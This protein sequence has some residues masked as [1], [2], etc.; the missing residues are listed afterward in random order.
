MENKNQMDFQFIIASHKDFVN[1][2]GDFQPSEKQTITTFVGYTDSYDERLGELTIAQWD[3]KDYSG[4]IEYIKR[5]AHS[6]V[7]TFRAG[8]AHTY[9]FSKA[10][11][12]T[13]SI[14]GMGF[15]SDV[16]SAGGWTD[17]TSVNYGFRSSFATK[18]SLGSGAALSGITGIEVQRQDAQ[19]TG[20][21]MKADPPIQTPV[22]RGYMAR[23][24]IGS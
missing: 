12:N 2:V 20:Y 3:A 8:L 17:K 4:N 7:S 5:N 10:V 22:A 24:L 13:T 16:S 19:I 23:V 1:F 21:N 14:F 11:S 6:H 18:F 9:N 15:R